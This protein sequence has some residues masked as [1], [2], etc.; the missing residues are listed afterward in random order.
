MATKPEEVCEKPNQEETDTAWPTVHFQ[1][2][3]EID[4]GSFSLS[5]IVDSQISMRDPGE[6]RAI[7]L[8]DLRECCSQDQPSYP[9]GQGE[10]TMQ[11]LKETLYLL[12]REGGAGSPQR[13]EPANRC[14][15]Q[16]KR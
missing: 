9:V 16:K 10:R 1:S 7:A 12:E 6:V 15:R 14:G 4:S 5:S 13:E 11:E 2:S 3:G 8:C